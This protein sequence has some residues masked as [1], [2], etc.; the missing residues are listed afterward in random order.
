MTNDLSYYDYTL[1]PELIAQHRAPE[2]ARLMVIDRK[3]QT[4][5]DRTIADLPDY[6]TPNDLVVVNDSRVVPARLLGR[7]T[8]TSGRWE[9]LFLRLLPDG[10]W[11]ILS[12]TKGK[13]VIGETITL[14]AP[15]GTE[16]ELLKIVDRTD[17][18]M[19]VRL[20]DEGICLLEDVGNDIWSIL[21]RFGRVPIPPYIR[22]GRMC[23]ADRSEYQ[24]VYA[25]QPGSVAAPTAGLHLNESILAK[26]Q[27]KGVSLARVTL[28]VG[29]GTFLPIKATRLDDHRMHHESAQLDQVAIDQIRQCKLSGGRI[30]AIGTTSV[31]VLE[32]A[33][34]HGES[35]SSE[36]TVGCLKPY[37]QETNL[38]IRP[39]YSFRLV[40]AMLTNFHL[41]QSTLL[42]LVRTFGGDELIHRAYQE[43]IDRRYRFY[44]YGD[45]MFIR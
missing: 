43:A 7:R 21:E 16:A 31:R 35:S 22:D 18:G 38:F 33:A 8:K 11:E 1:P 44:S 34:I 10:N 24:T 42:V 19:V 45:A 29:L 14:V 12:K 4:I 17:S 40:D 27:E 13:P 6:L 36:D 20:R 30:V 32:S 28:H 41:P 2:G 5:E 26:L 9:G 3:R 39:P 37:H 15:D 25:N 23:E